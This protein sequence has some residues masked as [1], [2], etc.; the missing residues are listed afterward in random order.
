V[1]K[2]CDGKHNIKEKLQNWF[3]NAEKVV[4]AGIGNPIRTDDSVGGKIV[5]NLEGRVLEKVYLINCETVP[6][7][8][9]QEIVD[10]QPSHVLIIDAAF[11]GLKP[12]ESQLV[13]PEQVD[14]F[15]AVTT[16]VLPLRIFCDY[17]AK[18]TGA[19]IA[20]LL[21][22]P[23]NTDFGEGLTPTVQVTAEK[24]TRI[25]IDLLAK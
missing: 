5:Q 14:S 7:S 15:P 16:H 17:I 25:L 4:I 11:L 21:I 2:V 22:E 13:F 3:F 12:G 19:K 20:L 9:M 6:E 24:I 8:F 1:F 10:F 18:M 23:E